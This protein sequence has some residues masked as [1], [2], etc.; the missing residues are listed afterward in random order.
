MCMHLECTCFVR[1]LIV[2]GRVTASF[3][4]EQHRASRFVGLLADTVMLADCADHCRGQA[5]IR[6]ILRLLHANPVVVILGLG[7]AAGASAAGPN[8]VER[9]KDSGAEECKPSNRSVMACFFAYTCA[10]KA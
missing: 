8:N 7:H 1:S 6:L 4:W 5:T 2:L 10:P 3:K 9:C